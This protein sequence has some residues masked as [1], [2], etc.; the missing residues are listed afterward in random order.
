[1]FG[2]EIIDR[3]GFGLT[4]YFAWLKEDIKDDYIIC[5][6][7]LFAPNEN[8]TY[9][10]VPTKYADMMDNYSLAIYDIVYG[11]NKIFESYRK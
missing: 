4:D 6:S 9:S 8:E 7:R 10:S 1:M 3:L 2:L 5:R 11:E